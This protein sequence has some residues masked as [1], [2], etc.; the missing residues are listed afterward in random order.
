MRCTS[1]TSRKSSRLIFAKLLSRRMPALF[2]RMSTRPQ[3][4]RVRLTIAAIA[5]SSVTD[6]ANDRAIPPD[7]AISA[8][9]ASAAAGATSFTTIRAPLRA[10]NSACSRPSPPPAPVTIATR[11]SMEW[12]IV[13]SSALRD[14]RR[15]AA[16]RRGRRSSARDVAGGAASAHDLLVE[17][18]H[19]RQQMRLRP[20]RVF[21]GHVGASRCRRL[22]IAAVPRRPARRS[23]RMRPSSRLIAS[24]SAVSAGV[25]GTAGQCGGVLAAVPNT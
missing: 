7:E 11:P 25:A 5:D 1:S 21:E 17:L 16:A 23:A 12:V 15:A 4:E 2:T 19:A 14:I 3:S 9:T 8:A 10:R 24:E 20:R 13:A 22:A 6:A 18:V